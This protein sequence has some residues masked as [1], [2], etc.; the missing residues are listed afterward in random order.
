[1]NGAAARGPETDDARGGPSVVHPRFAPRRGQVRARTWWGRALVRT[2]E[3][4]A[5]SE[6]DLKAARTLVREGRVGS[7]AIEPGLAKAVVGETFLA[8]M[9]VPS[10][11]ARA[12]AGFAEAV[13]AQ[14]GRLPALLRGDL[15]H[16]L[17][18]HA[19]EV[20]AELI[21]YA[22]ELAWTCAC[23]AWVDPCPHALAL[24]YQV[25]WLADADPL[26]LLLLRGLPRASLV[27]RVQASGHDGL[28]RASASHALTATEGSGPAGTD[29]QPTD[30]DVALDA[31]LR[32]AH[33]LAEVGAD[34][35]LPG[36]GG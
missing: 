17:V 8:T 21:P 7:I 36:S 28:A 23:D 26:V 10:F 16:D 19:D 25:A 31:A 12:A 11:D 1:M 27:A 35:P 18:E 3:E 6:D 22:G 32:A 13:A 20:G 24:A 2:L 5:Y 14:A 9:T 34:A 29:E 4:S 33:L 30:L 15:P